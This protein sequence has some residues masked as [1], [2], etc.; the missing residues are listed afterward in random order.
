MM[1]VGGVEVWHDS[2]LCLALP[3]GK[4]SSLSFG[5]V[6]QVSMGR[7]QSQSGCCIERKTSCL[8]WE[9]NCDLLVIQPSAWTPHRLPDPGSYW[10]LFLQEIPFRSSK[11]EIGN[12]YTACKIWGSC[13]GTAQESS[14]LGWGSVSLSK[15]VLLFWRVMM[16]SC[17]GLIVKEKCSAWPWIWWH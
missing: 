17:S 12:K 13:S 11:G 9:S 6:I 7:P 2:V 16:M 5:K 1:C 15:W 14:L 3:E 8:C 10:S 4:W